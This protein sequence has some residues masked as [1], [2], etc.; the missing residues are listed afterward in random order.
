MVWSSHRQ[1]NGDDMQRH[2]LENFHSIRPTSS[3]FIFRY[4]GGYYRAYFPKTIRDQNH[5]MVSFT[6]RP[7][8]IHPT[9]LHMTTVWE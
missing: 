5:T 2:A 6:I 8:D 7:T 9:Q 1:V 4:I 3:R